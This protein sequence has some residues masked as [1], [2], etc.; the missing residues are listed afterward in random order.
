MRLKDK[1]IHLILLHV[2]IGALV[3]FSEGLAKLYFLSAVGYFLI[4]IINAPKK[5]KSLEVLCACAYVVGAEVFLR[6]NHGTFFYEA[7]KYLVILFAGMGLFYKGFRLYAIPY[8]FYLL[9]LIPGIYVSMYALNVSVNLRKA[10]AFNL[11][12]P[13]CLGISALFCFGVSITKYQLERVINSAIYPLVSLLFYIIFFNPN[14]SEVVYSTGSNFATSGGFGPNQ[15]ATVLGLGAFFVAV[16]FFVFSNTR[17]LRYVDLFFVLLFSFRAVVTFS[18]GGV[19]TAVI[20]L[21]CFLF[22]QFRFMNKS[23]RSHMLVSLVLFSGI[24]LGTWV[25]SSI[26]TKGLIDKRYANQD[27][28]GVEKED[29]TTG[30]VYLFQQEIAEFFEN[31]F[32]GVGVG[33]IKDIRFQETGIQAAS[34][35]EMSRIVAEHGLLG[36]LAFLILLFTP[37][38]LRLVDRSNVL[39]F[40]FYFF[41]FLTINHS[42]MR[43][44]AP[45]F[46]YALSLLHIKH[47]QPRLHREQIK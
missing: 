6:M 23:K 40:S 15:V 39:F 32:L 12:G 28:R 24:I 30:R 33:R 18:R 22:F 41:W 1:H 45:A 31:P 35:N 10:V 4:R 7:S 27:V 3:Y 9:L 21:A 19:L 20:M 11:S 2:I 47:D 46:I 29:I 43:I 26:Q 14:V 25:Y 37:L 17:L 34:H 13:V 5:D 38:L 42:S 44:A 16:R 36:I 8:V